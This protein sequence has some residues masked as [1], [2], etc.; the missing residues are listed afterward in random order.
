MIKHMRISQK[1][2]VIAAGVAVITSV[3]LAIPALAQT[4]TNPSGNPGQD[5][6]HGAWGGGP[7]MMGMMH[8]NPPA[9]AGQVTAING[10]ALTVVG[11]TFIKTTEGSDDSKSEVAE[12]SS[13]SENENDGAK[14]SL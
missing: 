2:A 8:V 10:T 5:G 9:A 14:P 11:H 6:S 1:Y 3:A 4:P 12:G 7:S 13:S